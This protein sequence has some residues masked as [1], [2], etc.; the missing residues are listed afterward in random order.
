MTIRRDLRNASAAK[1]Y[2]LRVPPGHYDCPEWAPCDCCRNW[3]KLEP[4]ETCTFCGNDRKRKGAE[5]TAS[6]VERLKAA[7]ELVEQ[8]AADAHAQ[9][10]ALRETPAYQSGWAVGYRQA[11]ED[12]V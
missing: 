8:I 1:C 9:L 10:T 5:R 7:L 6:E 2:R 12:G 3:E 4:G 11:K